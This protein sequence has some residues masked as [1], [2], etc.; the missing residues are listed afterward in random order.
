MFFLL[1]FLILLK[2]AG[3]LH[4]LYILGLEEESLLNKSLILGYVFLI[5][6]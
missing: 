6:I 4:L 5:R 1:Y 2:L 3:L